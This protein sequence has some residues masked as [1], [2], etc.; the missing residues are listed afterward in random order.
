MKSEL[1]VVDDADPLG[2]PFGIVKRNVKERY[3]RLPE[4]W[5]ALPFDYNGGSQRVPGSGSDR[6]RRFRERF[7]PGVTDA[8]WNNWHWQLRN[9]ITSASDL[10]RMIALSD[11][12]RHALLFKENLLPFAITPYYGALL[13]PDNPDHPLRRAVVP[14]MSEH[15]TAAGEAEDPLGEE[16]DSPLP[17][18]VKRYPDRVLF[19]VT[20]YCSTYCRYCTRSRMVGERNTHRFTTERWSRI[21]DYIGSHSEIRDVLLSGG[22]PLTMSDDRLEWLLSRL[23]RIPH[24]EVIRIGTKAPV[25]LPQRVTPRLVRVLKKFHPLWMSIH[26]THPE[27]LTSE[28]AEACGR[29]ADGGIPLQSQTVL[30][31]GI[32]DTVDVMKKLFHGLVAMRVRPY[33]LYQCDPIVGSAHFRTT[34]CRGLDII[35]GLRGHTS[36]FAVPQYV[37]DAPGGGGKIPLLP[38]YVLG[39]E[40][41][42]ILM[43]NYEGN[44]YRYHDPEAVPSR[45][46]LIN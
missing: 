4:E 3:G 11:D 28:V 45:N 23:R 9:R 14:V 46:E 29:L 7:Y 42:D 16:A 41:D 38:E 32:N 24:V 5:L 33:Y 8:E 26:F 34:V 22:D 18:L 36:G 13:D 17:G 6:I 43:R 31:S 39:R 30:L 20:D 19:L 10:E 37:I 1:V 2:R 27:E 25:V 15:Q 35:E 40:G 44:V 21:I 12:E